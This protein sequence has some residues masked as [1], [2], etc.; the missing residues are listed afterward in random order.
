[1][2]R[3]YGWIIVLY[4]HSPVTSENAAPQVQYSAILPSQPSNNMYLDI[5]ICISYMHHHAT[6]VNIA[7][8][9]LTVI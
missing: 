9:Y 8:G 4:F 2:R 6:F 5:Y 1:M 7:V 3:Q